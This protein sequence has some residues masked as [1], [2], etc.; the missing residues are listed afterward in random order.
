[1]PLNQVY[2]QTH[3]ALIGQIDRRGRFCVRGL[4]L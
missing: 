1:M 3:D 4:P 2:G